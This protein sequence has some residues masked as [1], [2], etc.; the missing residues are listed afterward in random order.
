MKIFQAWLLWSEGRVLE[1]MDNCLKDSCVASQLL[2]CIQ[3]GLLCVQDFPE[4]RPVMS[5]V[6]FMLANEG[7]MLPQP[8][9]PG[10]FREGKSIVNMKTTSIKEESYTENA[11]SITTLDGR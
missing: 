6:V 9:Q 8:K 10:F 4:D 2:R 7:A 3:V 5:S 1:L 11:V